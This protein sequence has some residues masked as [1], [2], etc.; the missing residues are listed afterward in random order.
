MKKRLLLSAILLSAKI[1]HAQVYIR[2]FLFLFAICFSANVFGQ[3]QINGDALSLGS[4]CFQ[5]T[6]DAQDRVGSVWNKD[7]LNLNNPFDFTFNVNLGC[8]NATSGDGICFGLQPLN[9]GIGVGGN[10]MGMMGISPS[11][12]VF[13]DTYQNSWDTD[14]SYDHISLNANGDVDHTT[15]NNLAGPFQASSTNADI[16]D[17][18]N[19]K[20]R[21]KWDPSTKNYQV[22]FDDVLRISYTANIISTIFGGNP[23]VYWGFTGATGLYHNDQ[24]FCLILAANFSA[25][26]IC[27]GVATAFTD[28]S[29]SAN[30]ITN[31]AWDF[32]DG[33]PVFSGAAAVTYKN[34]SHVYAA[35]GTYT[36]QQTVTSS[37]GTS[38]ISHNITVRPSPVLTATPTSMGF[39]SGGTTALTLKSS[40]A[41]ATIAWTT[42]ATG[43]AVTGYSGGT[44]TSISQTLTATGS[45]AGV[46][47]YNVTGTLNGCTGTVAIPVTVDPIPTVTATPSSQT[48]CS[49]GTTGIA[50]TSA[51][52]G[53][54][55]TWTVLSSTGV[56]GAS[57]GSGATIAQT[58]TATGTNAGTVVYEITPKSAAPASCQGAKK[59]VTIT[60]NPRPVITP[61]V[62]AQT[63]CSGESTSIGL[64]SNINGTT[65]TWVA[66]A[67]GGVTGSSNGSG[68]NIIQTLNTAGTNPGTV[69]YTITA[70]TPSPAS[71]PNAAVTKVIITVHPIPAISINTPAAICA[72]QSVNLI[73]SVVPAGG[74]FLWTPGSST[75]GNITVSPLTS[76]SYNVQYTV[77]N[78]SNQANRNVTVNP[79]PAVSVNTLSPI[80][81][82]TS[83]ALTATGSPAGGSYSW[84][85]GGATSSSI[86]VSPGST[87]TY[88]VT[89]TLA[90]TC[91]QST[92]ATLTVNALPAVTVTSPAAVCK[93]TAAILTSTTSPAGGTY[94]WSNGATTTSISVS[95]TTTTTYTLSYTLGTGCK[96]TATGTATITPLQNANFSYA[97]S[98]YCGNALDTF[99]NF[100]ATTPGTFS[101]IPAG[102]TLDPVTGKISPITS[103]LN[104][105]AIKYTTSGT[106]PSSK[107]VNLSIAINPSADFNY[108]L[109]SYCQYTGTVL[110]TFTGTSSAGTFSATPPGLVFV[111]AN[112]GEI[113]LNTS[114][115]GN[116]IIKNIIP[117]N[118]TCLAD[119][120]APVAIAIKAAPVLT[121]STKTQT[122]CSPGATSILLTGATS[123]D[124][125]TVSPVTITG[126]SNATG[127]TSGSI[128]QTLTTS[129]VV[130]GIV[131]YIVTPHANGCVGKSDSVHVTVNPVPT[132]S[133]TPVTPS[134]CSG[135]ITNIK[136]SSSIPTATFAWTVPTQTNASGASAGT[137]SIIQQ[138]LTATASSTGTVIYHIIPAAFGSC[139][140]NLIDVP[141]IVYPNPATVI[142]I[143]LSDKVICSGETTNINLSSST[144]GTVFNWT[145]NQSGV[146]GGTSGTGTSINDVLIALGNIP[147]KAVYMI[148]G[149]AN[150]CSGTA[151]T[152][153]IIVNPIPTL[154]V[155]PLKQE[156]CSGSSTNI[157]LVSNLPGASF[158]WTV[159]PGT[160]TGAS[161]GSTTQGN[162]IQTLT[163][164]GL[165]ADT[166]LYSIVATVNG[167]LS[168]QAPLVDSVLAKITVNP[169]PNAM[170]TSRST[171]CSG[172]STSIQI[173]GNVTGT[174]Y[175]YTA[176]TVNVLGAGGGAG[177]LIEQLLTVNNSS[178]SIIYTIIPTSAEGCAGDPIQ[179]K[180]VVNPRALISF[181]SSTQ[182]I[183]SGTMIS[184]DVSSNVAGTML[185]WTP[186]PSAATGAKNGSGPSPAHIDDVL[187]VTGDT[188]VTVI[189]DLIGISTGGCLSMPTSS[190]LK[191][192]VNPLPKINTDSL[193]INASNCGT[194]TGSITGLSMT[195]GIA[196]LKY[197]W[198]NSQGV[199]IGTNLALN[200]ALPGIYTLKVTDA[201]GCSTTI[202]TDNKLNI[203][204]IKSVTAAFTSD[205]NSGETPLLVQ[206]YNQSTGTGMINYNWDFGN[207]ST[208]ILKDPSAT[209]N[210][211]R[212][213]TVCLI[214]DDGVKGCRDTMCSVIEALT[215]PDLL[216][217]PNV[218]TPNG[219]GINDI[220]MITAKGL[221]T[222]NAQ[223]YNRWGEKLYEWNTL[224]GGWD[225]FTASGLLAP[226][227]TYYIILVATGADKKKTILPTVKQSFTLLR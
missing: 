94:A 138:A 78:C 120:S 5:L 115:P 199:T 169:K 100:I 33:S 20:L 15:S 206:F 173:T 4:N 172:D 130:P 146:S 194:L 8:T 185:T 145:V 69:E 82:G 158:S 66:V 143:P 216:I 54:T 46:V 67:T 32:G 2:S 160:I 190:L 176:A 123:Y 204:T 42:S 128:A 99:P 132:V 92:T 6:P 224:Y 102:L 198:K 131:H 19:H 164:P 135:L 191:F 163:N 7:V 127:N 142:T 220:L 53:T 226:E 112:T 72:G 35:G 70:T 144:A 155:T 77:N 62:G 154:T 215:N 18:S 64:Q 29:N 56:S 193:K 95:P 182:S 79:L 133:A 85:P 91:A 21:V 38:T 81:A 88:T 11:V 149:I 80:C 139:N 210:A 225:G 180:V 105:Y 16:E 40:L 121:L 41:S 170:A 140:G 137:G 223:I 219:D 58:L 55:F 22:W 104:T 150:L 187:S 174:T 168:N 207:G 195:T 101:A 49:G 31:W 25:T 84:L 98:T 134:V 96:K 83:A 125:T 148:T 118:G 151:V 52:T 108:T 179:S 45:T 68:P 106:C 74:T 90:T 48:F 200:P 196:P 162:I 44:G 107:T 3:Y 26:T 218:F 37:A 181:L 114:T 63:I 188:A 113:D 14:P 17:C 71:C 178:D 1:N 126:A 87:T 153:S 93:G 202:G 119:T 57:A 212:E 73:A 186:R 209:F 43:G 89:Y 156:I 86:T 189:Y 109:G 30:P 129:D 221:E 208:S 59:T 227:G 171:I 117:K 13:I 165:I 217:V 36:V 23:N 175:T 111:S 167:C 75:A 116:Y 177:S 152:D 183:C 159:V 60:V 201:N 12:G 97:K 65:Y 222:V 10:G 203:Q 192:A 24:R 61:T 51:V 103:L 9:S 184:A 213:Y 27:S 136:L 197:E 141:V 211:I 147:G 157:A 110:P 122:V 205:V 124:W 34:P 161:N 39:C 50:L 47:T 214:V 28:L 166:V 76:T